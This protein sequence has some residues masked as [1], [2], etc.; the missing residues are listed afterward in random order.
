M[1]VENE[2]TLM[3]WPED[4][5]LASFQL[6]VKWTYFHDSSIITSTP[7][8]DPT[9]GGRPLDFF[10]L[11]QAVFETTTDNPTEKQNILMNHRVLKHVLRME[12]ATLKTQATQFNDIMTKLYDHLYHARLRIHSDE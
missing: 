6:A 12:P 11:R 2:N 8:K 5:T 3:D 4:D 7:T 1:M 10:M 9:Y